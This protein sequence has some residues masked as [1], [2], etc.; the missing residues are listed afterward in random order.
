MVVTVIAAVVIAVLLWGVAI[1]YG[2][3]RRKNA[4]AK[5]WSGIDTQLKRRAGLIPNL[6]DAVKGHAA[7][8]RQTFDDL[9]R[10][11]SQGRAQSG[12]PADI[13]GRARTEA[14]IAAAIGKVMAAAGACPE[15]KASADFRSL[16]T[17]LA[18]VE[19][20]IA[21]ARRYYNGAVRDFNA[22]IEQF[23]SNVIANFGSFK[24]AQFFQIEDAAGRA[25]PKVSFA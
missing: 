2:L 25:V 12:S 4:V 5:A 21:L 17:D 22:M 19:E 20:Q 13:A 8:E 23:P 15:L 11:G 14:A 6:L 3:A 1:F 18:D 9:A 10:L 7:H 24:P 16:Q